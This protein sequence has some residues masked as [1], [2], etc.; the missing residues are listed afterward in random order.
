MAFR[1]EEYAAAETLAFC[2]RVDFEPRA[3]R[4]S[5][6]LS[7]IINGKRAYSALLCEQQAL[8]DVCAVS[9]MVPC[10]G[11]ARLNASA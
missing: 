8:N 1:D 6:H 9:F 3:A 4:P 10:H 7:G 11:T 5:I 2:Y